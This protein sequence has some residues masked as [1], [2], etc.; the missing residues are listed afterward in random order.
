MNRKKITKILAS[1]SIMSI[2]FTGACMGYNKM[3][4]N[5]ID[6]NKIIVHQYKN[7]IV[8]EEESIIDEL[9]HIGRIEIL[10]MQVGK[11]ISINN[12]YTFKCFKKEATIDY[13]VLSHFYLN[14]NNNFDITIK[15][16]IVTVYCNKPEIE[17]NILY[18]LTKFSNDNGCL[19]FGDL[20]I[21][22]EEQSKIESDVCESVKNDSK[23]EITISKEYAEK[24]LKNLLLK[25][26]S[27]ILDVRI[28][29]I[30]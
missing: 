1:V 13:K 26:D 7:N 14:F 16:N 21:T 5:N 22:P 15:N 30:E 24:S 10:Q 3:V 9:N 2:L 29:Y 6:T 28:K 25:I 18:N 17:T 8:N 23:N 4:N 11:R 12:D 20:K 27:N 19:S